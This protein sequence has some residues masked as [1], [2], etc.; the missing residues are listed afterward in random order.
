MTG[1]SKR[2]LTLLLA[3][4]SLFLA[5]CQAP[6]HE[7]EASGTAEVKIVELNRLQWSIGDL[8]AETVFLYVDG[9][10]THRTTVCNSSNRNIWWPGLR[11]GSTRSGFQAITNGSE[12]DEWLGGSRFGSQSSIGCYAGSSREFDP[13]KNDSYLMEPG[14]TRNYEKNMEK[15]KEGFAFTSWEFRG[16][17]DYPRFEPL[18]DYPPFETALR[19]GWDEEDGCSVTV[20][21]REPSDTP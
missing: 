2:I 6:V 9:Q 5:T 21:E 14:I 10:P 1:N 8:E 15:V 3:I 13:K 19:F 4:G 11:T 18:T 20:E 12:L 7:P 17:T 16:E